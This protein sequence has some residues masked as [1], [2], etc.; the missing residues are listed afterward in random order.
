MLT[1]NSVRRSQKT[2]R[3]DFLSGFL[4]DH[5]D[6][7]ET[8]MIA[9]SR[10]LI[11]AGSE[12]TATLLSGITYL[13]LKDC[14]VLERLA[15]EIRSAFQSECDITFSEVSKLRYMSASLEE[16]MR[17]YPPVA[18]S[19]PRNVPRGGGTIGDTFVPEKV[20]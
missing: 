18:G 5:A 12:T 15:T 7:T 20:S 16:A 17:V 3:A 8:E 14:T 1:T 13:L 2:G 11:I 10:T 9:T 4:S 6:A 19:F